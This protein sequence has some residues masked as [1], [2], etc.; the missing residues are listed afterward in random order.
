MA[1]HM[2]AFDQLTLGNL[3]FL[4]LRARSAAAQDGFFE[5]AWR[6]YPGKHFPEGTLVHPAPA[7]TA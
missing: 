7:R 3:Y 6:N 4:G 5:R 2:P 1:G